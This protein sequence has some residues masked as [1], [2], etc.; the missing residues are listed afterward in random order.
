MRLIFSWIS[1]L[2]VHIYNCKNHKKSW[3][4]D[5]LTT[6]ILHYKVEI[7]D[8]SHHRTDL[9]RPFVSMTVRMVRSI[10]S[11]RHDIIGVE[12]GAIPIVT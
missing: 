12:M 9:E 2:D 4:F 1:A 10:L 6:L 11:V 8:R 7:W 3:L 5:T